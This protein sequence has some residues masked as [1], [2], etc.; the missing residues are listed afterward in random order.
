M[1]VEKEEDPNGDR[2]KVTMS[3]TFLP[4]KKW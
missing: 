3:G 1:N 4:Y 2:V